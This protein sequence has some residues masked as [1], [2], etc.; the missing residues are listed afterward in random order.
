L[1]TSSFAKRPFPL[2]PAS[3][4]SNNFASIYVCISLSLRVHAVV[5]VVV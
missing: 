4:N 2:H 1:G 5:V 3:F